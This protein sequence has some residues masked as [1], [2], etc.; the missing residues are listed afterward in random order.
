M[1]RSDDAGDTWTRVN[2]ERKLRQRAWYYSRIF[3]DPKDENTVY[4]PNVQSLAVHRRRADLHA[5]A[6]APVTA[7]TTISGSRPTTR[8]G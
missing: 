5:A 2:D 3:A 7:T 4:V 1:F 8:T 6:P